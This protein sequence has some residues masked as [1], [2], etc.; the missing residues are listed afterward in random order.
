M[1]TAMRLL[2]IDPLQESV[3]RALMR[4]YHE[5]GNTAQ[6][7]RQYGICEKVLR[8]ELNVEPEAA[9]RDLR[10]EILRSRSSSARESQG[11]KDAGQ[12]RR[13]DNPLPGGGEILRGVDAPTVPTDR[14]SVAVLS[15]LCES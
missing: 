4:L 6:A 8:R 2:N 12:S 1:Q 14:P 15:F 10:R 9:T 7:L 3:H 5:A 13:A 11:E